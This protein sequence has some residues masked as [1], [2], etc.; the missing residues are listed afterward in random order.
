M[1][2]SLEKRYE[3][4]Y[5]EILRPIASLLEPILTDQMRAP[6]SVERIDRIAVRAKS[7]RS[8]IEKARKRKKG[9]RRG[10]YYSDPF[11]QIQDQI[12][13]RIILFYLSDVEAACA[14]I[15]KYMT[16]AEQ[17]TKEPESEWEFGY[18]GR[19]Y[20]L[21]LPFDAVPKEIQTDAAPRHFELQVRTLFQHAWSE[22]DHDIAYKGG[23][24]LTALQ[25]RQ[26]AY[27][28]AQ[29]WGADRAFQDLFDQI[30]KPR[31]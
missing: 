6:P 27:A 14:R 15:M 16:V 28:A 2:D 31:P 3:S 21:S 5:A 4:Y 17:Q 12:G 30:G 1:S 20:I 26:C 11:T 9:G 25:Q 23:Q 22:A 18:F 10:P 8:F 29:G 13:A 7:P 19:H 24:E